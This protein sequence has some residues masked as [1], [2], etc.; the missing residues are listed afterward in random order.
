MPSHRVFS[1]RSRGHGRIVIEGHGSAGESDVPHMVDGDGGAGADVQGKSA[2]QVSEQ[3]ALG[4]RYARQRRLPEL[5]DAGQERLAASRAVVIGAGGL[6]AP[7]L[8]YLAAAGIGSLTVVDPDLVDLTNLHRQVLFT[9][10]DV[11]RAK[12][13]VAAERLTLQN[14]EVEVRAVVDAVTPATALDL[15]AGHDLVLDGS[16]NFP[17]RYL[18]SDACEI[19][20][21]PLVWGSILAFSGQVAV[22][23]ADAGGPTYRDL[24]PVPPRPGEVPS[25]AEAGVLGML[26]GVIGSTMALEAVKVLT[27]MGDPLQGR[28]ALYDALRSRW[29]E[30]PLARDPSR[31]AVTELEDLRVTCALP[32]PSGPA[33]SAAAPEVLPVELPALLAAGVRVIDLRESAEIAERGEVAGAEHLPLA[34]LLALTGEARTALE[35]AVL[36]CAGGTRSGSAQRVLAEHGVGVRS[37]RGGAEALRALRTR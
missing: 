34:E 32:G 24:H 31:A 29:D 23:R 8:S 30:L 12:A 18:A 33:G 20:R 21:L 19:L 28:V 15:L 22:F 27:G 37:L 16:D 26:C 14:P 35:G 36:L 13:E 2:G 5:G 7:L 6:G 1:A 25:C 3:G 9:P 10:A 11:G 17:T 4:P